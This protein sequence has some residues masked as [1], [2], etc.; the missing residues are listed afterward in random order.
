MQSTWANGIQNGI[1]D[2]YNQFIKILYYIIL[3]FG[4]YH[5]MAWPNDDVAVFAQYWTGLWPVAVTAMD[6][7]SKDSWIFFSWTMDIG[8]EHSSI[9]LKHPYLQWNSNLSIIILIITAC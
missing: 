6:H 4:Y 1:V 3:L 5:G 2:I 8:T 9:L 7:I